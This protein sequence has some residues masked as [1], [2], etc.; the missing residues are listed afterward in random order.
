MCTCT[1]MI[2]VKLPFYINTCFIVS[3]LVFGIRIL[4]SP[5][6]H[7][8]S[9]I[10]FQHSDHSFGINLIIL[11]LAV[12]VCSTP[13]TPFTLCLSSSRVLNIYV[14]PFPACK[15]MPCQPCECNKYSYLSWRWSSDWLRYIS[16]G[17]SLSRECTRTYLNIPTFGLTVS[18]TLSK[19]LCEMTS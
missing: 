18:N 3:V 10:F 6:R 5:L 16:Y 17:Q 8:R 1:C 19:Y 2:K 7:I 15:R 12:A 14:L 13:P 9:T 11:F 4:H